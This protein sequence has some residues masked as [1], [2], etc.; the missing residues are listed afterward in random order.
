MKANPVEPGIVAVE[1]APGLGEELV[2]D[3]VF[4]GHCVMLLLGAVHGAASSV[5]LARG[6][7]PATGWW[8]VIFVFRGPV[9]SP[10]CKRS[11]RAPRPNALDVTNA[12]G[13]RKCATT[14]RGLSAAPMGTRGSH[15]PARFA[16]L[17]ATSSGRGCSSAG[18]GSHD[19]LAGDRH[20][21]RSVPSGK[22][23]QH[24]VTIASRKSFGSNCELNG[25]ILSPQNLVHFSILR[26]TSGH[27]LPVAV[28]S[29]ILGNSLAFRSVGLV[30][31]LRRSGGAVPFFPAF[32]YGPGTAPS[33][34]SRRQ[35]QEAAAS[36][37]LSSPSLT[38][39]T[40]AS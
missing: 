2:C 3:R 25:S 32:P 37:T 1:R 22:L 7:Q 23:R 6:R 30:S 34:A 14:F 31:P 36:M 5:F 15:E 11:R 28:E 12:F 39:L 8:P 16:G 20:A 18:R 27:R 19:L 13:R 10:F 35:N 24:S 26:A 29:E 38:A 40:T 17:V 21:L 33:G 4:G 9:A